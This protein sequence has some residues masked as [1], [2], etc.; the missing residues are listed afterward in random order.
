MYEKLQLNL[1]TYLEFKGNFRLHIQFVK[2]FQPLV[3]E[4]SE[5]N[6]LDFE[7]Y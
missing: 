6:L 3:F 1:V 5:R 2:K 4:P 7:N